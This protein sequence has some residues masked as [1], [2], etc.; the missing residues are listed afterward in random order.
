MT[1]NGKEKSW[2]IAIKLFQD[3][4]ETSLTTYSKRNFK[5]LEDKES[6]KVLETYVRKHFGFSVNKN[7]QTPYRFLGFEP[8]NDAIWVYLE[9]PTTQD[10]SGVFLENSLLVESFDDQTNLIQV[11]KGEQKKSFLFQKGKTI[12]QISW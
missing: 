12:Q 3:D 10:L 6:E 1:Y 8:Q 11:A 5:I 4:L 7:L 2:E 9:V